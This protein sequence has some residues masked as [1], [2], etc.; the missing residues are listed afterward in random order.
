M[1]KQNGLRGGGSPGS[2]S[3]M[4]V[5]RVPAQPFNLLWKPGQSLNLPS[6]LA[7][8][9]FP[10]LPPP[11]LSYIFFSFSLSLSVFAVVVVNIYRT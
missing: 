3:K 1:C 5:V 2:R 10:S 9:L 7:F 6:P 8:F 11:S 4:L